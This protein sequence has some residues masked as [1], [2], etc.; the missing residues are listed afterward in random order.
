LSANLQ[1]VTKSLL[2]LDVEE[3]APIV[4]RLQDSDLIKVYKSASNMQREKLLRALAPEK[5]S[6][7]LIQVM[8]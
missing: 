3:I 1:S 8:S 2:N 7:I 6:K 4:N 5:A